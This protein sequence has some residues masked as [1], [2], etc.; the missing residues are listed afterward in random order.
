[1]ARIL[2][3]GTAIVMAGLAANLFAADPPTSNPVAAYYSGDQ[4]YPAWTDRIHWDNVIDM[5]TFDGGATNFERFEKARDELAEHGGGVLYYPAGEYDFSDGPFDG[6]SGRGLMLRSGVV[7][8]GETPKGKPKAKDGELDPPTRFVFGFKK[9]TSVVDAGDRLAIELDTGDIRVHR[10]K[11]KKQRG[12]GPAPPPEV[13]LEQAPL[14]L[15]LAVKKGKIQTQV[16]GYRRGYG[17]DVWPGK[18]RIKQSGDSISLS[19]ELRIADKDRWNKATYDVQLRRDGDQATGSFQGKCRQY[20]AKGKASGRFFTITSETPRDWNVIGQIPE[21]GHRLKDIHNVGVCWVHIVGGTIWFGPDIAWGDTWAT[22]DSWKS[23]Y[24]I[25]PWAF[26]QPDGTHPWD[27]FAGGGRE[28]VGVGDGR[29]VFGCVLEQSCVLNESV[30]MGRP[31]YAEGFGVGG[32]SMFKFGP[33]IGVYGSRV[34][35]ANNLLPLSRGRNFKYQQTTRH[36]FPAGGHRAGYDP[37]RK[38]TVFFDYNKIMGIDVNKDMLG[39]TKSSATGE[40]GGGYFAPGVAVIDNYVYNNGHKGFNISG[41]WVTIARNHNQRQKLREGYDPE[42]ICGWELTLDGHLETAPGGPGYISDNLSRAFDLGGRNLWVHRNTFNN[43]G[44][45]PGN[46]GEGILCQAHGGTQVYSWSVTYNDHELGEG[47]SSYIGGWDVN[48]AGVLFGW[49]TT[50]GWVGSINVGKRDAA[51]ASFVGNKCADVKPMQG[52]QVGDPGGKLVPPRNV[53]AVPYEGDAIYI[54]WK[55]ASQNEV[56]FRVDRKIA[57]GAWTPIA[58]R[59]PQI[60][61]DASNR[62]EWIDFLAPR[63]KP[64]VYR[65]VALNS[66]DNDDGASDPTQ[67]VMLRTK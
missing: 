38:S 44:S 23:P 11:P 9:R 43:L 37:P 67:T 10:S 55:D 63:G 26:R 17:R 52:S 66:K 46:D 6:P 33:R 31:D 27:P 39:F 22:A 32:Y 24:T 45:S 3:V 47:Q 65:V 64:L 36:T 7:I 12:G 1:M 42:R 8:C 62:P 4:G 5:S 34:F 21:R 40:A 60:V 14:V 30:T 20:D 16:N 28:F 57:D 53:K 19:V 41:D 13:R 59:P 25:R 48:M 29:L 2:H 50:A 35:V 18:A 61:G 58:Y 54:T 56:G 15:G 49:N 51:D